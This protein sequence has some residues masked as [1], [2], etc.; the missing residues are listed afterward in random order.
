MPGS[1]P[2][3]FVKAHLSLAQ[4]DKNIEVDMSERGN[5][6]LEAFFIDDKGVRY[7][8]YYMYIEK[9]F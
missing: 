8:P 3:N 6:D 5:Y 4:Y 9:L 1:V 2:L 7:P